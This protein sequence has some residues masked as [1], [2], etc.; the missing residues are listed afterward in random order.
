MLPLQLCARKTRLSFPLP[1]N[2][3]YSRFIFPSTVALFHV[4]FSCD[5]HVISS[6]SVCVFLFFHVLSC[7]AH[8]LK[9][10]PPPPPPPPRASHANQP[11]HS[12][13]RTS[14]TAGT[15]PVQAHAPLIEKRERPV[16]QTCLKIAVLHETLSHWCCLAVPLCETVCQVHIEHFFWEGGHRLN[17]YRIRNS[18]RTMCLFVQVVL[19]GEMDVGKTT[20]FSRLQGGTSYSMSRQTKSIVRQDTFQKA[21]QLEGGEYLE[22]SWSQSARREA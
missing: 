14:L 5:F 1:A 21:F 9:L 22:V 2:R 19:A 7:L 11:T 8:A 10:I 3:S 18:P 20:I 4:N 15:W 6:V 12:S 13:Q 16:S 17:L